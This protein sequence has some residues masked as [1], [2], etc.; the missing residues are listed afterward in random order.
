MVLR[1]GTKTTTL[2]GRERKIGVRVHAALDVTEDREYSK[3][4]SPF[5]TGEVRGD[6]TGMDDV[7]GS[8]RRPCTTGVLRPDINATAFQD[9]QKKRNAAVPLDS[10]TGLC[11]E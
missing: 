9:T 3:Q 11:P 2:S 5:G 6:Y 10:L 1:Q 4:S 7:A 8:G